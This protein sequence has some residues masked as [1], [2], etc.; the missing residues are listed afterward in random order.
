MPPAL[1]QLL[2]EELKL[3][4]GHNVSSAEGLLN[5]ADLATL[6]VWPPLELRVPACLP[7]FDANAFFSPCSGFGQRLAPDVNLEWCLC[8]DV[9]AR[10]RMLHNR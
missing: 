6:P 4:P 7:A 5:L 9:D 2:T 1:T 10:R 3:D 8:E